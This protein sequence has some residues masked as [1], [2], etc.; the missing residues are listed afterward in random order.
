[1]YF[2]HAVS[3]CVQLVCR[4][5]VVCFAFL[6]LALRRFRTLLQNRCKQASRSLYKQ[7]DDSMP[8]SEV[9]LVRV[10]CG[11]GEVVEPAA[12]TKTKGGNI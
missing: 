5:C 2:V 7:D 11:C 12:E 9:L 8:M 3:S 1:M 6:V 10:A 4:R